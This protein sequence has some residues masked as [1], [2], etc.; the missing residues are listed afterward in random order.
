MQFP[1]VQQLGLGH[2]ADPARSAMTCTVLLARAA[3]A[4]PV[5]LAGAIMQDREK[6]RSAHGGLVCRR[7]NVSGLCFCLCLTSGCTPAIRDNTG[8]LICH[9]G[10]LLNGLAS[11]ISPTCPV[12]LIVRL[13]QI[14]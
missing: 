9:Q 7:V 14:G 3:N 4:A 5:E 12:L 1:K 6:Q 13:F 8:S 2:I 11:R 10:R